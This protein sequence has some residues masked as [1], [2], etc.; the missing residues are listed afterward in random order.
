MSGADKSFISRADRFEREPQIKG[1][2]LPTLGFFE[3]T[4]EINHNRHSWN[5]KKIE[6]LGLKLSFFFHDSMSAI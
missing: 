2:L 3:R 5:H 4:R 1:C 6:N